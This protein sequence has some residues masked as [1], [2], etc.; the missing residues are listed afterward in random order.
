MLAG[1]SII[2]E[3]YS[4]AR[5]NRVKNDWARGGGMNI[6]RMRRPEDQSPAAG[7]MMEVR[8]GFSNRMEAICFRLRAPR[9]VA[10]P[11]RLR[12]I[13][14]KIIAEYPPTFRYLLDQRFAR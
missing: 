7:L 9:I 2:T 4:V 5:D 10:L 3:T 12:A 8:P 13:P 6:P 1:S 11:I 14:T